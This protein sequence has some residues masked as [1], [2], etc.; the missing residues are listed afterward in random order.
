MNKYYFWLDTEYTSFNAHALLLQIAF[1]ITN[2][3]YEPLIKENLF[4][5]NPL[6]VLEDELFTGF[7]ADKKDYWLEK[8]I[9]DG[10]KYTEAESILESVFNDKNAGSN[11]IYLA[12]NSIYTDRAIL[13]RFFP[14]IEKQLHYRMLDVSSLKLVAE[15]LKTKT[16]KKELKHDALADIMES[17]AEFRHY[18]KEWNLK[19]A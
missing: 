13:K 8:R 7:W 1:I 18:L 17:I 3:K 12:G 9:S 6:S 10:I 4:I 11:V 5:E 14:A 16:Y 2:D 15:D 19:D